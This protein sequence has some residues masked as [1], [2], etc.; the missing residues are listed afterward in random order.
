M[1][2]DLCVQAVKQ[3][4]NFMEAMCGWDIKYYELLTQ[5][6]E[7]HK[8]L[9]KQDLTRIYD[10]FLIK[11]NVSMAGKQR[12]MPQVRLFSIPVLNLLLNAMSL[13]IK[14]FLYIQNKVL[15]LNLIVATE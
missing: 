8:Y 4:I 10:I 13:I 1:N 12:L 15:G 2:D 6:F 14:P 11:K 3:L 7:K 9:A 5:D